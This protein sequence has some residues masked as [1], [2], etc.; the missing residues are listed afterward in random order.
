MSRK[1]T[2]L[3]CV[4]AGSLGLAA[5]A[6]AAEPPPRRLAPP[7]ANEAAQTAQAQQ[8]ARRLPKRPTLRSSID[9]TGLRAPLGTAY[10]PIGIRA[11]S[12]IVYPSMSG[13]FAY[14]DNIYARKTNVKGDFIA[15]F[16][17][18]VRVL[19]NWSQHA[20]DL[21]VEAIGS[22]H[23]RFGSEN[24]TDFAF[25]ADGRVDVL[26][27]TTVSPRL[28]FAQRTEARGGATDPGNA[29]RPTNY[30][31]LDVAAAFERRVSQL[32]GN[33]TAA[34]SSYSYDPV[35]LNNGTTRSNKDREYNRWAADMRVGYDLTPDTAL[36]LRA[37]YNDVDYGLKPPAVTENRDSSGFEI[38]LGADL[39]ITQP[40]HGNLFVGYRQQSFVKPLHDISG[41]VYSADILWEATRLTQVRLFGE[42]T[43][44]QPNFTGTSGIV[45]QSIGLGVRHM[46]LPNIR[47]GFQAAYVSDM[48][49]GANRT[50]H[51]WDLDLRLDYLMNRTMG[52][53]FGYRRQ[54]RN[55]SNSL[56]DFNRDV[57]FAELR[58]DL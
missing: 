9:E 3:G 55:S 26:R 41:M 18:I 35:R 54:S 58:A 25:A 1:A 15:V 42:S 34:W 13:Q 14:D 16:H 44:E 2:F 56:F 52:F 11:G 57:Y 32:W 45:E 5:I 12:F 21:T 37:A 23:G 38:G 19:S 20:L 17:P 33:F 39:R 36:Y 49:R 22:F 4:A 8:T 47:A 24:T 10:E 28:A 30:S 40:L 50:D 31:V 48:F 29:A 51:G 7:T 46:L 27:D 43:I 6:H 53:G